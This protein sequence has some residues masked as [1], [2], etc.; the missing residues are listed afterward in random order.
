MNITNRLTWTMR[1]G[2]SKKKDEKGGI[3]KAH[4]NEEDQET[5]RTCSQNGLVI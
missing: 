3:K 5:K 1:K 2:R 4:G